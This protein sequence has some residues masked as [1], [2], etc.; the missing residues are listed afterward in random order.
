MSSTPRTPV[1]PA[2]PPADAEAGTGEG[3][4]PEPA[5][6][7]A[8]AT[9]GDYDGK[10]R[11]RR[12]SLV[13]Q[14]AAA[15]HVTAPELKNVARDIEKDVENSYKMLRQPSALK[16]ELLAE[17]TGEL[18]ALRKQLEDA[19]YNRNTPEEHY[20]KFSEMTLTLTLIQGFV[21]A[22]WLVFF[23][24]RDWSNTTDPGSRP[25]ALSDSTVTAIVGVGGALEVLQ[26]GSAMYGSQFRDRGWM[27]LAYL[28]DIALVSVIH[29]GYDNTGVRIFAF[30]VDIILFASAWVA[31]RQRVLVDELDQVVHG[32]KKDKRTMHKLCDLPDQTPETMKTSVYLIS[33]LYVAVG[34]GIVATSEGGAATGR[35]IA[36]L[37]MAPASAAVAWF[38][39]RRPHVMV[40]SMH[41]VLVAWTLGTLPFSL[42]HTANQEAACNDK[43]YKGT[44]DGDMSVV[45]ATTAQHDECASNADTALIN[46][47]FIYLS[48]PAVLLAMWVHKRMSIMIEEPVDEARH[49]LF[50]VRVEDAAAAARKL[51]LFV[52]V[53]LEIGVGIV[54]AVQAANAYVEEGVGIGM[55]NYSI[56][57]AFSA[58]CVATVTILG[59]QQK[60]RRTRVVSIVLQEAL[61]SIC[62]VGIAY[63]SDVL[64]AA[65]GNNTP[66]I[67]EAA[68]V[69]QAFLAK[70][71]VTDSERSALTGTLVVAA[72]VTFLGL[73]STFLL[74]DYQMITARKR[75]RAAVAVARRVEV[76]PHGSS[77][78]GA[79]SGGGLGDGTGTGVAAAPETS[80][81]AFK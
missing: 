34:A 12:T 69:D 3:L 71:P 30:I 66:P 2:R 17:A 1:P 55:G 5:A 64:E 45:V 6:A 9:P 35:G 57:L 76:K 14:A 28:C 25:T 27:L 16:S 80:A 53:P 8:S 79:A 31:F 41:V 4:T 20:V 47:V 43:T 7:A 65:D 81:S 32:G 24:T 67:V 59:A 70:H 10:G 78:G 44:D 61:F 73:I 46:D 38:G 75:V 48:V 29:V 72:L 60:L 40:Y 15:A 54:A 36:F 37:V 74:E 21:V 13:D 26:F 33:L 11:A 22:A 56:T 39:H 49:Y 50:C 68:A 62:F 42:Q 19:L 51:L 23:G 52:M 58:L 77:S 63:A 18:G